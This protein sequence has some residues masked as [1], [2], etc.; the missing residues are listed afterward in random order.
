MQT[1]RKNNKTIFNASVHRDGHVGQPSLVIVTHTKCCHIRT[2][3]KYYITTW[4]SKNNHSS[5]FDNPF[6]RPAGAPMIII[7]LYYWS[8]RMKCHAKL[9]QF[10]RRHNIISPRK[11]MMYILC[12]KITVKPSFYE[13]RNY[14][15]FI[16]RLLY[17]FKINSTLIYT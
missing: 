12:T 14:F 15:R 7:L 8:S 13:I 5:E 17:C 9:V 3:I 16:V 2:P 11:Y 1:Y 4:P 10:Q 6:I